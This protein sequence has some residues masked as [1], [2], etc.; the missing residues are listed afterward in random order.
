MRINKKIVM[1]FIAF[2]SSDETLFF[3]LNGMVFDVLQMNITVKRN[4]DVFLRTRF[5][6]FK[7]DN[8]VADCRYFLLWDD[9]HWDL[10]FFRVIERDLRS[11][12]RRLRRWLIWRDWLHGKREV[13][14]GY[15]DDLTERVESILSTECDGLAAKAEKD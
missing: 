7:D 6:V 11:R 8:V 14:N 15:S 4:N 2:Y 9:R 12:E 5:R 3:W 13:W 10:E 1:A